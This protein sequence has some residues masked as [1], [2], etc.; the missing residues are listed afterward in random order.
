MKEK[1]KDFIDIYQKTTKQKKPI[2]SLKNYSEWRNI[3][4]IKK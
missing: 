3:Y 2:P 4:N 1:I